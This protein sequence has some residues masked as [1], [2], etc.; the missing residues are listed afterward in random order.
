MDDHGVSM[1]A[2]MFVFR[3]LH[4]VFKYPLLNIFH[5]PQYDASYMQQT[6]LPKY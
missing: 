2:L 1:L 3:R 4:Q 6:L 5:S